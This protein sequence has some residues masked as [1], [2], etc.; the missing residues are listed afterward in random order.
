[1]TIENMQPIST[2]AGRCQRT[3]PVRDFIRQPYAW[4]GGYPM[5]ALTDDCDTLCADCCKKEWQQVCRSTRNDSRDGW[6]V[7]AVTINWEN[8]DMVC[9]HCGDYIESAYFDHPIAIPSPE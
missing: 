6:R 3:K 5:F 2:H 4:P 9:C 7:Q 1:M 8:P